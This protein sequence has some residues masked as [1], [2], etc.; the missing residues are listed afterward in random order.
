[1]ALNPTCRMFLQELSPFID[2]ELAPAE[3]VQ[4][5]RHLSACA[6]CTGRV[7]DLRAESGLI[8]VGMEILTDDVDFRDF[9][10]RV[11]ARLTPARPGLIERWKLSLG[12]LM[13]YR[14]G[15]AISFAVAGV[16]AAVM[17]VSSLVKRGPP[18]GYA[19]PRMA[20]ESVST[21]PEAHVAPVVMKSQEGDAIIW[22]VSHR[23]GMEP[24]GVGP[25]EDVQAEELD[26]EAKPPPPTK[27]KLNQ[28]RP[29]GGEL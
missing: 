3:R 7:A 11:V 18:D 19:S 28:E 10:Q 27:A 9:S 23:H 13:T 29:R 1:M 26:M 16:A 25:A 17:L 20:V 21:D 2:G 12:E 6:Q 24:A 5:E 22:L 8:R 4:V 15:P 14:R